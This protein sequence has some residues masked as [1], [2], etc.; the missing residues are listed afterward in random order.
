LAKSETRKDV[1]PQKEK[2]QEK[3]TVSFAA[4]RLQEVR[5]P[6]DSIEEENKL[7]ALNDILKGG[8]LS[9]SFPMIRGEDEEEFEQFIK[10]LNEKNILSNKA[11][12]EKE[13]L[14]E[15]SSPVK[16][17]RVS[18]P[19]RAEDQSH[20]TGTYEPLETDNSRLEK[21]PPPPKF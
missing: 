1:I 15:T 2:E 4:E 18:S 5:P 3:K 10:G 12:V 16:L 14:S 13:Q 20:I 19:F 17:Q 7:K 6:Q 8:K 9:T 21:L 11:F